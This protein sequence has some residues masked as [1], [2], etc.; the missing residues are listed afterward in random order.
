M[1]KGS[2]LVASLFL[3]GLAVCLLQLSSCTDKESQLKNSHEAGI[4]KMDEGLKRAAEA[5]YQ[6]GQLKEINIYLGEARNYYRQALE[7]NPNHKK[8]REA[9]DKLEAKLK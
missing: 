3:L 2:V 5:A 1:R 6:L 8:A 7:L 9:L 4:A